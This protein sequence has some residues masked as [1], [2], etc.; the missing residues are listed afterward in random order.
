M[1]L[2]VNSISKIRINHNQMKI[3]ADLSPFYYYYALFRKPKVYTNRYE[4]K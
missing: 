1:K 4:I 3:E 2:N